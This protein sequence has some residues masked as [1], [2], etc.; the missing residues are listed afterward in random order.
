M[1]KPVLTVIAVMCT[2]LSNQLKAQVPVAYYD[3]ENNGARN[4]TVETTL[5]E[6]IA[7]IGSPSLTATSLTSADGIGNG[8]T[9]GGGS[10]TG[11]ALGYYGFTSNA[12]ST[13]TDPNIKF[14]PF[15]CAGFSTLTIAMDVRGVGTQAPDNVD[16]YWS[17]NDIVYTRIVVTTAVTNGTWNTRTFT[18]PAGADG[19]ATLYF[20]VIGYNGGATPTAG[21]GEMKI[22][23]FTLRSSLLTASNT[24]I[25][26]TAH[27]TGLSSGGSFLPTYASLNVNGAAINVTAS[28]DIVFTGTLT[29]TN[30]NFVM[31]SDSLAFQTGNI[32]IARN[33]TS[34]TG[35]IVMGLTSK[36]VFGRPGNT[37][38][39]AF[40]IPNNVFSTSPL[41]IT[42]L[43]IQHTNAIT[44]NNQD[45]NLLDNLNL[46]S[47]TLNDGGRTISLTLGNI[48]GTG[49]QTGSGLIVMT[50]VSPTIS[51]ATLLNLQLNNIAGFSLTG[52]P[53]IVGTLT[54]TNGALTV[55]TNTLTFRTSNTP[56]VK[57]AG[58]ITVATT[59]NLAFGT[60]G[61][62]GGTAFTI[63]DDLFTSTPSINNFTVNRTNSLTIGNQPFT[64]NGTMTLT[65]GVFD[66]LNTTLTFQTGNTPLARTAGTLTLGST[67]NLVFGTAGNLGGTAFTIPAS[68]FTS[69][70][71]INSLTV[72]R[73]NALTLNSQTLTLD[74]TLT[75]T[76]G[77]F[78]IGSGSLVLQTAVT[79][80][81][82][83]SG[84]ITVTTSSNLTFG[85]QASAFTIP[86][87][88]FTA[89][90]ASLGN[91]TINRAGGVTVG[92]QAFTINGA[93]TLTTGVFDILNTAIIF[94]TGAT[95]IARTS[96]TLTVG[97]LTNITFGANASAFTIPNDVFT[98]APTITNLTINRAGGVTIGNQSFTLNGILTLTAG[99]FDALNTT[100]TFQTSN[101]P[102]ARTTGTLTLGSTANLVFGTPGNLGGN[103]FTIPAS[104][105]TTN[106]SINS[107]TVNRTNALTWNTQTLTLDGALTLTAGAFSIG[108]GALVLQTAAT[109]IVRTAGTLIVTTS[110]SLTFGTQAAAFTIPDNTFTTAPS[111][112]NLTIDRT[113]GITVGNQNFTISGALTLTNGAFDILNTT[114]TFQTGN[115]PIVRTSGSITTGA[116]ANLIFGTT[117]NLGGNAF[118]IP[119]DAFTTVP[120]LN[121]FTVNRT[122]SLTLGNQGFTLA[123]ILTL[124]AGL[125]DAQ[126]NTLIFHT[127]NT[128]LARTTGTLTLGST[129]SLVFGTAGN[130]G[131]NAFTLPSNY[132]TTAPSI[133]NFTV[134]RTNALTLG[135]Q[136][137]TLDGTLTLTAGAFAIGGNT[138]TLQNAAT[139]I[140]RVA[141]TITTTT[142]SS[143]YFGAN[144]G[145]FAIP[146]NTFTTA[147]SLNNLTI[148]R[149]G[150]ITVGNQSF[151]IIGALT[152][153]NGAFDIANSTLTFQTGNT[154]IVKTIGTLTIGSS[155]NLIFG[156][157][158]NLGGTAFVIPDNTFTAAP[159]FND[160]TVQRTNALTLGNQNITLAGSLNLTAGTLNDAGTTITV[161]GNITGT[162]TEAGAGLV[163]MTG[164]GATI[165]GATLSNLQLNNA[166]GFSLSGSPI[167]AGTLTLTDGALA[168]GANTLT[169]RTADVPLARTAG[170]ITTISTSN[171]VFGTAGNTGGNA[172][173]IPDNT[174]TTAPALNN[175]TVN[176][177]NALTLGN[178]GLTING[179]LTL[180]A[181]VFDIASTILT[182][183]NGATPIAR[184]AGTLTTGTTSSLVFGTPG[185][186]GG[187]AFTVPAST[188]TSAPSVNNLTVN[189]TNALTWN[190]QALTIEG[191]LT[192]TAGALSIAAT[193]LNF[194]N[195]AL[196]IARTAGTITVTTTSNISFGTQAAAFTIPDGTFTAAPSINDLTINRAGG[197]TSGNQAFTINGTLALTDGVFD[198]LNNAITFTT[199]ATPI[200]RTTGTL[201]IGTS[202]NITFNTNAAGFTIPDNTFTT[203]PTFNALTINR[204]GGITIGNQ[205][206][207]LNGALTLTAGVFDILNT[208]LTLQGTGSQIARNGTSQLGTITVGSTS[209]LYFGGTGNGTIPNNAF[210][211]AP[212]ISNL[213]VNRTNTLTWNNQSITL[214]GTLALDAGAISIGAVSLSFQ[215]HATPITRTA[216]TLTV[217]TTTNISF[218]TQASAFTIPDGTFTAAPSIN[219]L[220]IDRAGGI[221]IGNQA[222]TINGTLA[223]TNGSFNILNTAI[224][225]QT[226]STPITRTSGTLTVG[227]TTNITFGANAAAF[228]IP[229]NT[230]TAAPTIT[231][232]TINRA[233]GITIGNQAF[234]LNGILTLTAGAFDVLNTTL[235]LQGTGST[236]ARTTGTLTLG[237]S[238][239]LYFGGTGN[240]TIPANTFTTAPSINNLTV[241]RTNT[242][243]WNNQALTIN[244]TLALDAGVLS[245]GN[246]TLTLQNGNTPLTRTTGTLTV[247]ATANLVF[248]TPGNTGGTAFTIPNSFFTATPP[249]F[250][251]FTINRTNSLTLNST[252]G[253][254]LSGDLNL[255]A[256][257]LDN[258]GRTITMSAGNITGTGT[259]TGAGVIT[260]SASGATISGATISN[261]TLNNAGGFSLTGSP[262]F[263]NILTLTNGALAVGANTLTFHTG[264]TPI[265]RTS[266]T[267]TLASTSSLAFGTNGSTGGNAFTIPASTFTAAPE[268]TNFSMNRTNSLTLNAQDFAITGLLSITAGQ[269]ILPTNYTF[270]LRSTSIT[271]TAL[272]DVVGATGVISYNSGAAFRVERYIPQTGAGIRAYRD[273]APSVNTGTRRIFD[274]WQEGG[275]NGL[276]SGVYYGTHVTGVV[277]ANPGGT[278]PA[279]GLDL[280]AS[281]AQSLQSSNISLLT[282]ADAF[283]P[284]TSTNQANDTLSALKGYRILIR[285]N[286]LVNLYQTPQP[287]TMNAPAI[288]RSTGSLITGQVTFTTTG[289]TANGGTN[290]SIRLNSASATGYTMIGNPYASP[291]VWDSLVANATSIQ[292]TYWLFDPNIGTGSYVTYNTLTGS[293]N[294]ASNAN[295]YIQPGQAIFVRNS[296]LSP[297]P[298]L[299]FN[300]RYKAPNI[301]NLT[302]V[303]RE[304][305]TALS[306]ISISIKKPIANRGNVTMDG[307]A[308]AYSNNFANTIGPEDGTKITNGAENIAISSNNTTLSIEGR[309]NPL[310]T[311]TI[312]LRLYQVT[313]GVAY[314]LDINTTDFVDNGLKPFL[315][316]RFT[317]TQTELPMKGIKSY[318]FVTTADTSSYNF[319]FKIVFRSNFITLPINFTSVKASAYNKGV[320]VEWSAIENSIANYQVQRSSDAVNF[321]TIGTSNAKGNGSSS[322]QQ[323]L[324]Y[325]PSP[326]N[327]NYYRIQ[328]TDL[329]GKVV[330]SNTVLVNIA[331]KKESITVY[332]N[333]IKGKTINL[334]LS[335][336][337]HGSYSISLYNL[338]GQSVFTGKI[339][340][341]SSAV[342]Q[343]IQLPQ[344]LPAGSYML[345]I[346]KDEFSYRQQV[347]VQ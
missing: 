290:T 204:A 176:R 330:Y 91:L 301:A 275:T 256:G 178:Q 154:P 4:T 309:K 292:Q 167:I 117:G 192:L 207:T 218:G 340:I 60:T 119:N 243:T 181:G 20:K 248:G 71:S 13:A 23:N 237:S 58:T 160:L 297:A 45:I 198:I 39:N 114:L 94:Q 326:L 72:N 230:F 14:G 9:Y 26:R 164:S 133:S 288:L 300:E 96:G 32:P 322:S 193:T 310:I 303:F 347:I 79:P 327:T 234:T 314:Q 345:S 76:A 158:G 38:G 49:T 335:N 276:V 121:N 132:F 86:D 53:T 265:A 161:A 236:I 51:G 264:N 28:S 200:T 344:T 50:G 145:S 258:A 115:T 174:F 95:P 191:T 48:T 320:N 295:K 279:T 215:T 149:A 241:N 189:R 77:A 52:S 183:Q 40:T 281:G 67:A 223:L 252:Q 269:L 70:P 216:G 325:D 64:I 120:S 110:S 99:V 140:V 109:P 130:T 254:T 1:F 277:G 173:V 250:A 8:V 319:R 66:A 298:V 107:L 125:L 342:S 180:T 235:T 54:L 331:N 257:T 31:N 268:F 308:V 155:A 175:F 104:T 337:G 113:G 143:I 87:G 274:T 209:S 135:N 131:G 225:F 153:T 206:F 127:S 208:T 221:T 147:P 146:D 293:S 184:T 185:N 2:L 253:L 65:A 69:N 136:N 302:G 266:G 29:L 16:V 289:T 111:L 75:L 10:N 134:N 42:A 162:G 43:T 339:N 328:S 163:L 33:G 103:A 247:G 124:T 312:R 260:M 34:Q 18:V 57:A 323:Y 84:T 186:V 25:S 101:T 285:G 17:T 246:N 202:T 304:A 238:A 227:A 195:G 129:A 6:S 197:V 341:N 220:T 262:I 222:F 83:T 148:D 7:G 313:A 318:A 139:P 211:A 37:G 205:A 212:S 168:A 63:P 85:T 272:V 214:A 152:L 159:S 305:P 105:F 259:E 299:V 122:N 100:L 157:T 137:L 283:Q 151:T 311:D 271:N 343:A 346:I 123:G 251:S 199:G 59:S 41:T 232:F 242:L 270:T 169:F 128:P 179:I 165:S 88:T 188:F 36:L 231:N 334:Q 141:G 324:W 47:G 229:D 267:I 249:S 255:T 73:T 108:S 239:N 321:T 61:N 315:V 190:T 138:L 245:L 21:D 316:D 62:L 15:N 244:G 92:N 263:T 280:T 22:D 97:A 338:G 278:D 282:G 240:S 27:G 182:F 35:N 30:G 210:T 233:G 296:S 126:N 201:T 287:T 294:I 203:A 196:P 150:G 3:F 5:Q 219:N 226:G 224:V 81:V 171:I 142:A 98:T 93:L 333:P 286:R 90:P 56:I 74:G 112:S 261:L 306:K 78:S 172:F 170:T 82:R 187:T 217:A 144:A 44:L 156:T 118:A 166:G 332:P 194:Q 89:S 177:T 228:T 11:Y 46:T 102:L 80:I 291:V 116:S 24:L 336:I 19:A 213:T 55:G 307:T 284:I 329:S 68:M 106:P 273:V 12:S 317:N